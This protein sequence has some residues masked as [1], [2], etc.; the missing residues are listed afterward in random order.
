MLSLVMD[1]SDDAVPVASSSQP[2]AA[3]A[4]SLFE[5]PTVP[6]HSGHM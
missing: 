6:T 2:M 4:E 1:D 3:S 5:N